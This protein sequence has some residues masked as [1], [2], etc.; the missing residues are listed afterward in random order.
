[1]KMIGGEA[2][3]KSM[4]ND[5]RAT[6]TQD[7]Q[8]RQCSTQIQRGGRISGDGDGHKVTGPVGEGDSELRGKR[9]VGVTE[10]RRGIWKAHAPALAPK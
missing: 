3:R 4:R 10:N 5:R 8:R 2:Q 7:G 6:L 9:I 1:M